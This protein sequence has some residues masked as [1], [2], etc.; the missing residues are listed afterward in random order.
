MKANGVD[1]E[2]DYYTPPE[3]TIALIQYL[4]NKGKTLEDMVVLEPCY[5]AGHISDVLEEN[6]MKVIKRDK[7]T[8]PESHDILKSPIP[9]E[10]QLIITNPPYGIKYD[11]IKWAYDS[12]LP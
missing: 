4:I 2:D 8:L 11:V 6:K 1:L 7:F 12:G 9:P 3:A 5:G 10:S